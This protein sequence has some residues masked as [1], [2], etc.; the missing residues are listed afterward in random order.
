MPK[1]TLKKKLGKITREVG[2]L[3]YTYLILPGP[4]FGSKF[5][6]SAS[7]HILGLALL[8]SLMLSDPGSPNKQGGLGYK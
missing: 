8:A 6:S 4:A 2:I 1:N 5:L 3:T 7:T